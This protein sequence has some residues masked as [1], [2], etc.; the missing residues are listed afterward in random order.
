MCFSFALGILRTIG[1]EE[2]PDFFLGQTH[3]HLA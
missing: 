1:A 2:Q 3:L